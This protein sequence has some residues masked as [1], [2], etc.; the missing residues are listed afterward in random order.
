MAK[1]KPIEKS[2]DFKTDCLAAL[3]HIDALAKKKIT[4][5]LHSELAGKEYKF[6]VTWKDKT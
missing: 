6:S 4:G 3:D 2:K 1:N 5:Y